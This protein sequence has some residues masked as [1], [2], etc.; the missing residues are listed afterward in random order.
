MIQV[1]KQKL[2]KELLF[3]FSKTK[4]KPIMRACNY[5][6]AIKK[7]AFYKTPSIFKEAAKHCGIAS[8]SNTTCLPFLSLISYN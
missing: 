8:R 7:G 1:K 2:R 6:F 3:Y 5:D 4:L